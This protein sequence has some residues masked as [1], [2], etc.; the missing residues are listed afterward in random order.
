M[1]WRGHADSLLWA[2]TLIP[3][4]SFRTA[5]PFWGRTTWN[6]AGLSPNETAAPKGL[7][8]NTVLLIGERNTININVSSCVWRAPLSNRA[9]RCA[10]LFRFPLVEYGVLGA[11]LYLLTYCYV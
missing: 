2:M 4:H 3:V 7:R 8:E 5:V 6:L 10:C 11:P 9:L 1:A